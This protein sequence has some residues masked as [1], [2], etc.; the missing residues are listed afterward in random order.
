MIEYYRA[1]IHLFE[2]FQWWISCSRLCGGTSRPIDVHR[3][4]MR[5]SSAIPGLP[6]WPRSGAMNLGRPFKAG[7]EN[8]LRSASRERR[9]NSTVAHATDFS[10]HKSV[11]A[12]KDPA[13]F[14]SAAARPAIRIGCLNQF[15]WPTSQSRFIVFS[16]ESTLHAPHHILRLI[17]LKYRTDKQEYFINAW[18]GSGHGCHFTGTLCFSSSV[19]LRTM[20]IFGRGVALAVS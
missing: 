6:N 1:E 16:T 5:K 4:A 19:Q 11:R 8:A 17:Q 18:F 3:K 13:K 2:N 14:I 7:A 9:L 20:L 10:F 15:F 12:L